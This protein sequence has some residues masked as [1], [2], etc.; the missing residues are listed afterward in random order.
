MKKVALLIICV[1]LFAEVQSLCAAEPLANAGKSGL[2]A[3]SLDHVLRLQPEEIDL[4]TAA[5]IVS[6]NWSDLVSGY[7]CREQLDRMAQE[8]RDIVKSRRGQINYRAVPVINEY[9][10]KK[11]RYTSVPEANDPNDLFLH[12]VLERKRGYCLSLS[13]LYLSLA[14]RLGL[15]IYGVVVPGH[16]F[17]RYDDGDVAFNIE[18]TSGGGTA[19]DEHYIKRFNVPTD[20]PDSVYLK[21]LDKIQTLGCLFNNLG[22]CYSEIGNIEYAQ[23]TLERAVQINLLLAES[24]V[25]LGNIYLEKGRLGDAIHQYQMALRINRNDSKV[26]LNLGNA[27]GRKGWHSDAISEYSWALSLDANCLKAYQYMAISYSKQGMHQQAVAQL[28]HALSL[29]PKDPELYVQLGDVYR[30]MDDCGQALAQY[31]RALQLKRDLADAYHSIGLCCRKLGLRDREIQ[32]YQRALAI[33]PDML[34]AM[35]NLGNAY[36]DKD[37]YDQAIDQ[38]RKA[39]R[40]KPDDAMV[41]YNLGT[42]YTN[43]NDYAQATDAYQRAVQIDPRYGDA[44]NGLAFAF[45]RLKKYDLAMQH[46]KTAQQLGIQ[47]DNKLIIAIQR[48]I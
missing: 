34:A 42:A 24:R 10:F 45:Y 41:H 25:N 44:Y 32:A 30:M 29:K 4:A 22:N 39:I 14:E 1:G 21:N 9:L 40:L 38:Y 15:P 37:Q 17:V 35:V 2:Y 27:Y 11:E 18:A 46:A 23:S 48:R 16:F 5:L 7:N 20:M 26:H 19:T 3:K 36:A 28:R 43:K 47:V 33:Q 6:E 13:I 8:I 31:E 12:R